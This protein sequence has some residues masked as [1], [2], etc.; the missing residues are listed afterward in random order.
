[1]NELR[2]SARALSDLARLY[3]FLAPAN[4]QA[5]IRIDES[6]TTASY[7][8]SQYP[9]IGE[10]LEQ[11]EPRE[12]RHIFVGKYE[13]CDEL[14]GQAI[15]ILRLWHSRQQRKVAQSGR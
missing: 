2:W 6:L 4:R 14:K 10:R 8:L 7:R 15:R 13:M 9:Q 3:E 5:A 1:M 12:I 11:F